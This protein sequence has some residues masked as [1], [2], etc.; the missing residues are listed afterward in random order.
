MTSVSEKYKINM[1]SEECDIFGHYILLFVTRQIMTGCLD[2]TLIFLVNI[3]L[4]FFFHLSIFFVSLRLPLSPLSAQPTKSNTQ[5][6]I[7]TR[8]LTNEKT[9]KKSPLHK[10]TI[11]KHTVKLHQSRK[12]VQ[13]KTRKFIVS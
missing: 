3:I 2:Y 9:P 6:L 1:I 11:Q 7:Q 13:E 5:K 8:K 10:K 4:I 12:H